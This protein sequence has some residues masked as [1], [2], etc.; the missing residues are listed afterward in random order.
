MTCID[1]DRSTMPASLDCIL[2][3]PFGRCLFYVLGEQG[4]VEQNVFLSFVLAMHANFIGSRINI[5]LHDLLP[6]PVEKGWG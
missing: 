5:K 2:Y 1:L 4:T 3:F 6:F